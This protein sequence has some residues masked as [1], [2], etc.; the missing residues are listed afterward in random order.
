MT[1]LPLEAGHGAAPLPST[2]TALSGATVSHGFCARG[3]PSWLS[4]VRKT[5][6]DAAVFPRPH[7]RPEGDGPIL[8]TGALYALCPP[9]GPPTLQT[10]PARGGPG[11]QRQ[12]DTTSWGRR[13]LPHLPAIREGEKLERTDVGQTVIITSQRRTCSGGTRAREGSQRRA[14]PPAQTLPAPLRDPGFLPSPLGDGGPS[15]VRHRKWA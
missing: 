7:L 6:S 11:N 15:H 1:R 8:L 4:G 5:P 9:P 13:A 10:R 12:P 2:P 3:Q 14:A